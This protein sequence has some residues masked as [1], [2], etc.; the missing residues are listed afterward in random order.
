MHWDL[1]LY[2]YKIQVTLMFTAP[3]KQQRCES[4]WDFVV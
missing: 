4:C 1:T 2:L 3:N